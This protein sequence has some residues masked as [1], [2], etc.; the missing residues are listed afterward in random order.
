M[1]RFGYY[2]G[3]ASKWQ[4]VARP[5][6]GFFSFA[7]PAKYVEADYVDLWTNSNNFVIQPSTQTTE[8]ENYVQ[9]GNSI[10]VNSDRI[11]VIHGAP[12]LPFVNVSGDEGREM[13]QFAVYQ[14]QIGVTVSSARAVHLLPN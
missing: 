3:L 2:D 6:G 11:F 12:P 5:S 8:S 9:H 13:Q 14:G 4:I 1:A 7:I 10:E